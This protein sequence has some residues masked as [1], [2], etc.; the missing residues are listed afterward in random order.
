MSTRAEVA[1]IDRD[2]KSYLFSIY[3]D[4]FP[5]EVVSNLL[6]HEMDEM[7]LE[8]VKR[9]LSLREDKEPFPNYY[10]SISLA[11]RTIEIYDADYASTDWQRGEVIFRGT[12]AEAKRKF[13]F[14]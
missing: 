4:A 14:M 1:L 8:D 10:F 11:D 12:F 9:K 6:N 13:L 2:N 5:D 3:R 7:E